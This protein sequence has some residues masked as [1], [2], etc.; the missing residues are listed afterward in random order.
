M[1]KI[2]FCGSFKFYKE[3]EKAAMMLRRMGFTVIVPQ[4]SHVRH[5]H[6]PEELKKGKYDRATLTKWEG[7]GAFSHLLNIRN[8]DAVYIF[9]KGSYLGPAVTVEIGYSLALNKPIFA[10]AQVRDITLTNFIKAVV[11]PVKLGEL[12][13]NLPGKRV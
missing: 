1:K 4:P 11:S 3:M 8:C 10:R 12:L 5:G 9:N 6:N 13:K 7:E 2:C